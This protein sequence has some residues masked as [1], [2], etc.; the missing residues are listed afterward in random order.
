MAFVYLLVF[1][2]SCIVISIYKYATKNAEYFKT[3]PFPSLEPTLFFGNMSRIFLKKISGFD[4]VLDVYN[5]F[6]NAK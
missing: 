6:P 4:L 2:I 3:K 1:V 5:K